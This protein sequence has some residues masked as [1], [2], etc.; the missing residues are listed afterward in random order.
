[1]EVSI[2]MGI[3]YGPQHT[4]IRFYKDFQMRPVIVGK[5]KAKV[6]QSWNPYLV[7]SDI[8]VYGNRIGVCR[9]RAFWGKYSSPKWWERRCLSTF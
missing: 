5:P 7:A 3:Q 8:V 9:G 1:M 6:V 4:T 2:D